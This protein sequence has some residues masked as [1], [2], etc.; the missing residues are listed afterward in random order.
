MTLGAWFKD[1]VYIP[2]GGSRNGKAKTIRNLF[3]VWVLTGIWHGAGW[4]FVLWGL[5]MFGLI[6]IEK[7]GFIRFLEK[8]PV[9]GHLYMAF[10]IPIGWLVFAVEDVSMIRVYLMRLFPFLGDTSAAVFAGD[11]LKYGEAYALSLILG[12]LC[13]GRIPEKFLNRKKHGVLTAAVLLIVFWGSIYCIWK[14]MHDPFLYF[15]F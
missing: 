12:I 7:L 5:L 10:W 15:S 6:A 3:V 4:N 2:L 13:I 11:Y 8:N 1:Y 9:L 14:G